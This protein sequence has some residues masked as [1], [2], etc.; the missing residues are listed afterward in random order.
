MGTKP[1]DV[2][3]REL[4]DWVSKHGNG[5]YVE[6]DAEP[7][8]DWAIPPDYGIQQERREN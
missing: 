7:L 2:I 1:L 5:S 6:P 8:R 3:M 4:D